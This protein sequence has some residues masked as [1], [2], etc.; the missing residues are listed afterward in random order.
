MSAIWPCT[1]NSAH[2]RT[3]ENDY[4]DRDRWSKP[5]LRRQPTASGPPRRCRD[6]SHLCNAR[7]ARPCRCRPRR[8][9]RAPRRGS[10]SPG[11]PR[12][13][14]RRRGVPPSASR[15]DRESNRG[16]TTGS[17]ARRAPT[18]RSG[19]RS[20]GGRVIAT[21]PP[22]CAPTSGTASRNSDMVLISYASTRRD[23][24]WTMLERAGGR[25][26]RARNPAISRRGGPDST[27]PMGGRA[28]RRPT[29]NLRSDIRRRRFYLFVSS[30]HGRARRERSLQ[31]VGGREA[32]TRGDRSHTGAARSRQAGFLLL[33]PALLHADIWAERTFA[34]I[35]VGDF[36]TDDAGDA[37]RDRLRNVR[38]QHGARRGC[39]VGIQSARGCV[40]AFGANVSDARLL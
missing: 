35:A 37:V 2:Q 13:R 5:A 3:C 29:R 4:R 27:I 39:D 1:W 40:C 10:A 25:R 36:F 23:S 14:H 20:I 38:R 7:P 26:L 6:R 22:P 32:G 17:P 33:H 11:R 34:A 8:F 15:R 24:Q 30:W 12:R 16:R 28:S 9:L 21:P 18:L 19:C 31:R